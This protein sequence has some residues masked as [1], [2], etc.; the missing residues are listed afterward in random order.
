MAAKGTM[1]NKLL[2]L[3]TVTKN[4][5]DPFNMFNSHEVKDP[6]IAV[7][8][9]QKAAQDASATLQLEQ[10]NA[11]NTARTIEGGSAADA[12]ALKKKKSATVSSQLG[13]NV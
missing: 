10:T 8:E 3:G 1:A 9:S 6:A 13:V 4:Q 2:N 12:D 5:N 7:Q 11:E